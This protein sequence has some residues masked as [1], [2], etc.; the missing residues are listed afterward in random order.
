[1]SALVRDNTM[2][3]TILAG[4]ALLL[5]SAAQA[6][7]T[8]DVGTITL[9]ANQ[10]GQSF[11]LFVNGGGQVQGVD[12]KIQLGSGF[13]SPGV[14]GPDGP[15]ITALDLITGSI[16]ASDNDGG[17]QNFRADP[18]YW[19]QGV[20][21]QSLGGVPANGRLARITVDTTG[22]TTGSFPLLLTGTFD[23]ATD[24]SDL[25]TDIAAN[26]TNGTIQIVPELPDEV[27]T[28]TGGAGAWHDPMKWT[29]SG[30]PAVR[31]V[32]KVQGTVTDTV[33]VNSSSTVRQ[34]IIGG[35][36]ADASLSLAGG[37]LTATRQVDVDARGSLSLNATL[38]TPLL[39]I[40]G[41][42][43]SV[44]TLSAGTSPIHL[45]NGRL[46]LAAASSGFAAPLQLSGGQ[47]SFVPGP[48]A[49]QLDSAITY[50]AGTSV[51]DV[52][53]PVT[54]T[55]D[56]TW[57]AGSAV[58]VRGGPATNLLRFELDAS[59]QVSVSPLAMISTIGV[60]VTLELAGARTPFSDG[61]DHVDLI[62]NTL[63]LVSEGQ[64][65]V[66]NLSG[67]GDL[68][69]AAGASLETGEIR[70]DDVTLA[71]RLTIRPGSGVS[72]LQGLTFGAPA[73]APSSAAESIPEPPTILLAALA[74]AGLAV[75]RRRAN[76]LARHTQK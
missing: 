16:F 51:L 11:D 47:L 19:F 22:F 55:G 45:N 71:G 68:T 31:W 5:A 38:V 13:G 3:L 48:T 63:L 7:P 56:Q 29:P 10:P 43:V 9:L 35:G 76:Y 67:L 72:V 52:G 75:L 25:P 23:G 27:H 1:M 15:N 70:Q 66:G 69:I 36:A 30:V 74:T 34:V 20:V 53:G 40:D 46:S 50:A 21:T 44:N 54:L 57:E 61:A 18:Q 41:G 62:N 59:D 32:A 4:L 17:Q 73:P 60:P 58:R 12:F 37:T 33:S 8:I 28:W 42:T 14:V 26:I 6:V 65:A 64:H 2:R 49:Y 24:F 39:E